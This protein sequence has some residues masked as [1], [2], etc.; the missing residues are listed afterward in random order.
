M[1]DVPAAA[2][3]LVA[4][5]AAIGTRPRHAAVAGAASSAAILVRPNLV[6]LGF[7]IGLFLLLRPERTWRARLRAAATYAAWS[8]PGCL[9]VAA[10]QQQFYGSPLSSGYGSLATLFAVDHVAPNAARYAS[11][12]WQA[13]TPAVA[14]AALAPLLLPGPLV[15]LLTA[16]FA[17]NAALYLPY[18]VFDD[19]GYTRFLLPTIPLLLIMVAAVAD[20]MWRRLRLPRPQVAVAVFAIA[21]SVLFVRQARD[22][23][24]FRLQRL[25]A[26]FERA[27]AYVAARLPANALVITSA[28]SGS[29][30]FYSGR[31]T[32]V[33]DQL[34]PG[35]LDRAMAWS[36]GRGFEPYLLFERGE[37]QD[38]RERFAGSAAA[39]LDWPP[40]AEVASQVRI[41]R[42][43]DR[44]RYLQGAGV[45]TEYAR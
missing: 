12:L 18:V 30:R 45:P 43:G 21:L 15:A 1:S 44:E 35:W 22:R 26:R 27:G 42:P 24:V 10:I 33:W 29:V 4:I 7:V 6:P 25:E 38:F 40:M 34:D 3:W 19:W 14:L 16:L 41:Y 2:L 17:V 8:V 28:E 37:E 32:L 23:S 9:A 11:W 31:R 13:L 39:R 36:R 5:A 20:A